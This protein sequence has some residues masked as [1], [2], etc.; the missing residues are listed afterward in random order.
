MDLLFLFSYKKNK[1]NQTLHYFFFFLES[2]VPITIFFLFLVAN[3][4]IRSKFLNLTLALQITLGAIT[5]KHLD[6]SIMNIGIRFSSDSLC[7]TYIA[8]EFVCVVGSCVC[9]C[10]FVRGMICEWVCMWCDYMWVCACGEE[11]YVSVCV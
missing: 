7:L 4:D 10:V 6:D 11:L 5:L 3:P 1:N 2:L 8:N 9:V